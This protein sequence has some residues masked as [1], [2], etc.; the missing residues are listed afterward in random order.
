MGQFK[1]LY[2][3][4]SQVT[5]CSANKAYRLESGLKSRLVM[6]NPA[7]DFGDLWNSLYNGISSIEGRKKQQ[8]SSKSLVV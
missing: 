2:N 4:C 1:T 3:L 8:L 5:I 7:M 6:G